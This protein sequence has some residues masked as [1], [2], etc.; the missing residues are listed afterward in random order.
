MPLVSTLIYTW[1]HNRW[2]G[3]FAGNGANC[4]RVFPFA[5]IVCLTYANIAY[6][7]ELVCMCV[8]M[9]E[10]L[11]LQKFPLDSGTLS[12]NMAGRLCVGGLAGLFATILTHP[13][14]VVRARLTVQDSSNKIYR[15]TIASL[16]MYFLLYLFN[17]GILNTTTLHFMCM[18]QI[19]LYSVSTYS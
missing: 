11:A 3:L 17:Y 14:D 19:V 10:L 8:C 1:I 2:S 16:L 12:L 7:S 6:V 18:M 4:L 13:I 5:G 15:G 9:Y